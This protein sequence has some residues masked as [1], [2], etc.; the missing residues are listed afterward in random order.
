[1]SATAVGGGG[2][3]TLPLADNSV[4]LHTGSLSVKVKAKGK[5]LMVGFNN[6]LAHTQH[7]V[8]LLYSKPMENIGHKRLE[9]HIFHAGNIFRAFEIL[10]STIQPTLACIVNQILNQVL[11]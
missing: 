11:E 9:S 2:S 3:K 4:M 5:K 8:D 1:M 6:L 10:R 7:S